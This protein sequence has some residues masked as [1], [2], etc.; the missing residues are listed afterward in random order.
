MNEWAEANRKRL[1]PRM[2]ARGVATATIEALSWSS[3]ASGV[4]GFFW[5]WSDGDGF[6]A[7]CAML[8]SGIAGWGTML[9]L[10]AVA[11]DLRE[12]HREIMKALK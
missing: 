7:M 11:K 4:G 2:D 1:A 12:I 3:L 6:G 5:L 8:L 10:A 9:T